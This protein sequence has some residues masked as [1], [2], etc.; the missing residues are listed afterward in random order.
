MLGRLI[1]KKETR[2]SI[3]KKEI[4]APSIYFFYIFVYDFLN[5]R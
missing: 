5:I 2:F 1:K 3:F 4:V